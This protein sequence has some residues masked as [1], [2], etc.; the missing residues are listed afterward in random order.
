M[1][2]SGYARFILWLVHEMSVRFTDV[3]DHT[4]GSSDRGKVN[5]GS[6]SLLKYDM[7]KKAKIANAIDYNKMI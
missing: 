7:M 6:L 1:E 5:F 4:G 2:V 3:G